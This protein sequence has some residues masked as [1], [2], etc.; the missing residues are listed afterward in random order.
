MRKKRVDY[1]LQVKVFKYLEHLFKKTNSM[2]LESVS[3]I[4]QKLSHNLRKELL[5]QA[6]GSLI[7]RYPL[8]MSI[9]SQDTL[10]KLS[11]KLRAINY[12]PEETIFVVSGEMLKKIN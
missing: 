11:Q 3:V 4:M 8:F 9:F 10:E 5:V 2:S 1:R 7:S 12:A 6:N